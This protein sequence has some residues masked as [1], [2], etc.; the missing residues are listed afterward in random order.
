MIIKKAGGKVIGAQLTAAEKKAMNLEIQRQL[1]DYTRK[2]AR[3]I[4]ALF[5]WFLHEEFGF[6]LERL[7]RAFTRFAPRLDAMCN[8]YEMNAEGDDV[9]LCT[10]KLKEIGADLEQWEKEVGD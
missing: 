10:Q 4:D 7:K 5:L 6:G 3:E 1:G 9:W 8:R 2:H